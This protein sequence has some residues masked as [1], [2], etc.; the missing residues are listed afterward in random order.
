MNPNH[1]RHTDTHTHTHIHTQRQIRRTTDNEL[2]SQ[3][4][5]R[6]CNPDCRFRL[7][8]SRGR[9]ESGKNSLLALLVDTG[10]S[11]YS[12]ATPWLNQATSNSELPVRWTSWLLTLNPKPTEAPAAQVGPRP[13]P[14][15]QRHGAPEESSVAL[16]LGAAFPS[17]EARET[18]RSHTI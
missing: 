14:Q 8:K 1:A 2:S 5:G 7:L 16:I 9:V 13:Q 11:N 15:R 17:V 4:Q 18:C 12:H 3:F 10:P 6:P